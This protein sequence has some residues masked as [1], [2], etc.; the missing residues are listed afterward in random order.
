MCIQ[1]GETGCFGQIIV[2]FTGTLWTIV[3]CWRH[4]PPSVGIWAGCLKIDTVNT[5]SSMWFCYSCPFTEWK[6]WKSIFQ[7]FCSDKSCSQGHVWP[8]WWT[9]SPS[10]FFPKAGHG[11]STAP[12]LFRLRKGTNQVTKV[13]GYLF[14][15]S[16]ENSGR[17]EGA[18]CSQMWSVCYI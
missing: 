9:V 12:D 8:C 10:F 2:F 17:T 11:N 3:S 1:W 13:P 4:S 16:S 5:S 14:P 15:L 6:L 7:M 18:Q